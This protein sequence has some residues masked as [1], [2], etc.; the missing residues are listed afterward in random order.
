MIIKVEITKRK[1]RKENEKTHTKD[2]DSESRSQTIATTSRNLLIKQENIKR[3]RIETPHSPC[4]VKEV[5]KMDA[6]QQ[7]LSIVSMWSL[8]NN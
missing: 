5:D 2:S 7:V 1:N 4:H 6:E 3:K 8:L